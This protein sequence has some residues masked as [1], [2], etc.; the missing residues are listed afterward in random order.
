[1][2]LGL[3]IPDLAAAMSVTRNEVVFAAGLSVAVFHAAQLV[4]MVW[5]RLEG[6]GPGSLKGSAGLVVGS[7]TVGTWQPRRHHLAWVAAV[8]IWFAGRASLLA[9]Y[10]NYT[11]FIAIQVSLVAFGSGLLYW[12]SNSLYPILFSEENVWGKRIKE[13]TIGIGLV[14]LAPAVY[15]LTY[16]FLANRTLV[17]ATPGSYWYEN[18]FHVTVFGT[19][20]IAPMSFMLNLM[21]PAYISGGVDTNKS[22]KPRFAQRAGL[23]AK[24]FFFLSAFAYQAAFY[25]PYAELTYQVQTMLGYSGN[26]IVILGGGSCAG[27]VVIPLIA[28]CIQGS[29]WPLLFAM[30]L[31]MSFSLWSWRYWVNTYADYL[32][33]GFL[34]GFFTGAIQTMLMVCTVDMASPVAKD[35]QASYENHLEALATSLFLGSL[36][37]ALVVKYALASDLDWERLYA[38][39]CATVAVA[40]LVLFALMTPRKVWV[41]RGP[42][43]A[44][45]EETTP[46]IQRT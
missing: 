10:T 4:L 36:T 6:P 1:M 38:A 34:Y 19:L 35:K 23:A 18:A 22:V 14:T 15:T 13:R 9:A 43:V 20:I 33:F 37:S 11:Q 21:E 5:R 16:P 26:V 29:H 30:Y 31:G 3:F 39:I 17:A 40:S 7:L 32:L 44:Q 46:I 24:F 41:R 27:R 2:T 45:D 8:A 12:L 42:R 28:S 25:I